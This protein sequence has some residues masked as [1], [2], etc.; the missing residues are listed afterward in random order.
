MDLSELSLADLK[1][2]QKDVARAIE[3]FAER[4]RKAALADLEALARERGFTLAQLIEDMGT[5]TRKPVAPK[6]AN[7]QDPSETWTGRGRKPRWVTAA[8]DAG[9]TMDDLAI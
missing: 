4:E 7:P 6:Y 5:K 9:K 2:L 1:K 3:N 8:L